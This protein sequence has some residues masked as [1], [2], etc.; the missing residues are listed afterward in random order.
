MTCITMHFHFLKK[1]SMKNSIKQNTGG[2]CGLKI[3]SEIQHVCGSSLA[4]DTKII[5][6]P[7]YHFL[8]LA[9]F[10]LYAIN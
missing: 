9:Q 7:T 6:S 1:N 5:C 2:E 3:V 8:G 10:G 4:N